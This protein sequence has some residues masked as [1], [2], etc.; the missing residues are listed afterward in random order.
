MKLYVY[1]FNTTRKEVEIQ[2]VVVEEKPKTYQVVS[3]RIPFLYT[4]R[5]DTDDVDN[6]DLIPGRDVY[7]S[8]EPDH[9]KAVRAFRRY[10]AGRL[11]RTKKELE[12]YDDYY[13]SCFKFTLPE[14]VMY[15]P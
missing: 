11:E 6:E 2:S 14:G 7:V 13:R 10:W 12:Q 4:S 9:K 1:Q 5:N 8:S 3:G 15:V